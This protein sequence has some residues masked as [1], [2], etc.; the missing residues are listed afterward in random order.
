MKLITPELIERFK[1]VGDQS[2]IDNPIVIA[3]FFDPVGSAS[4]YATYY[5]PET[6]I[7][8]GYVTGLAFDEWGAF[9][10]DELESVKRPLGLSIERDL[11]F[12]ETRFD[13][14]NKKHRLQELKGDEISKNKTQELER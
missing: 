1:E 3:K 4:W 13:D 12:E 2:E 9:S 6:N 5:N 8:S 11:H 10:I 14:L 7:C